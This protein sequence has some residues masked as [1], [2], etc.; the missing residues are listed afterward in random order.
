MVSPVGSSRAS[1]LS[2]IECTSWGLKREISRTSSISYETKSLTNDIKLNQP[3][4]NPEKR[5]NFMF[6]FAATSLEVMFHLTSQCAVAVSIGTEDV[7]L[8]PD[9]LW[10]WHSLY[11]LPTRHCDFRTFDW[12]QF[13]CQFRRRNLGPDCPTKPPSLIHKEKIQFSRINKWLCAQ[14]GNLKGSTELWGTLAFNNNPHWELIEPSTKYNPWSPPQW[15]CIKFWLL[16]HP[17]TS[18]RGAFAQGVDNRSL[19]CRHKVGQGQ[20]LQLK[21]QGRCDVSPIDQC[22]SVCF[23]VFE[24]AVG[25]F[26]YHMIQIP[27]Q[28]ASFQTCQYSIC[29]FSIEF[30]TGQ[31]VVAFTLPFHKSLNPESGP[32]CNRAPISVT[33]RASTFCYATG[34]RT[35]CK[36]LQE[37]KLQAMGCLENRG[38][39]D[40]LTS[41]SDWWLR[42]C[43]TL[44][45]L[46]N[47]AELLGCLVSKWQT[48]WKN[49][50][51]D[52]QVNC[53]HTLKR[54]TIV[55]SCLFGEEKVLQEGEIIW[56]NQAFGGTPDPHSMANA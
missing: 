41:T 56:L 34:G 47:A 39:N 31:S 40:A 42:G 38:I 27:Q 1:T 25:K 30:L 5:G 36:K 18:Y 12:W 10:H 53:R 14:V 21:P 9:C 46:S 7:K 13:H 37:I 45:R 55:H 50:I 22:T 35:H 2:D 48:Y 4:E 17:F 33:L 49:L 3:G 19:S 8:Q 6:V 24:N 44:L 11:N 43:Q 28:V 32:R 16:R 23:I 29:W 26:A 51:L 52:D 54:G 15:N 20:W